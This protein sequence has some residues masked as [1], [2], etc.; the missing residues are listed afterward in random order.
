MNYSKCN[1]CGFS[2]N[3]EESLCPACGELVTYI[4]NIIKDGYL[5][6]SEDMFRRPQDKK[7]KKE[8]C[9]SGASKYVHF[10]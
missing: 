10:Y 5:K 9:Y 7:I 2:I 1:N 8:L 6:V 3:S 4:K